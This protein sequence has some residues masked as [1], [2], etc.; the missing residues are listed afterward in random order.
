MQLQYNPI[1]ELLINNNFA[2]TLWEL[3]CLMNTG[4][5]NKRSNHS[6]YLNHSLQECLVV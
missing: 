4:Y 6:H 5:R 3:N 1:T 2:F